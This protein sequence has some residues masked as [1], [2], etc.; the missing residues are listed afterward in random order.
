MSLS[1]QPLWDTSVEKTSSGVSWS[2]VLAGAA[3]AAALALILIVLGAGLGMST[4]SPWP[5]RGMGLS[6]VGASTI[7]WLVITQILASGAGGYLAGRLRIKWAT[8]HTDEVYFRDTA[9][10]FLSWAIAALVSACL[11]GAVIGPVATAAAGMTA[12]SAAASTISGEAGK[13]DLGQPSTRSG[14]GGEGGGAAQAGSEK[15]LIDSLFRPDPS[16]PDTT[17]RIDSAGLLETASIFANSI[18]SPSLQPQDQQYLAQ[19]VSK[20]TGLSPADATKRVNDTFAIAHD[21][22]ANAEKNAREAADKARKTAAYTAMWMFVSLLCGAFCA[23]LAATY[24]GR[25]RDR[26][27]YVETQSKTA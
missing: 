13:T 27:A 8:V 20:H 6:A 5:G 2:A 18:H 26:V 24:G 23:S 21:L 19:V 17:P 1:S 4:I 10:G 14:N 9:H 15:Y 3:A 25:Q 7:A 22:T 12:V 11:I 16:A